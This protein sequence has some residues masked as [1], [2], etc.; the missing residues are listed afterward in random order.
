MYEDQTNDVI[1]NRMLG[2]VDSSIDKREGA[3]IY[4]ATAPAAFELELMYAELDYFLKNTFGDTAEREYL[5]ERALE[6]GLSPYEASAA[7][8]KITVTPTTVSVPVG[9][10][11]SYDDVNYTVTE[12][13]GGGEYLAVCETAGTAGN[14]PTGSLVSI[15]YIAG[16]KTATLTEIIVYGEEEED[17][18]SFRARYL[19]SFS[20]QAYGG[21]IKDYQN[22]VGAMD[23]V[24]GVKVYPVWNGGGTVKV[25]F[26]TSA[27]TVPSDELVAMVQEALD[28]VPYQQQGVGIAPIG[29]RV[30]VEAVKESA[31]NIGLNI[32]F[33]AGM[34]FETCRTSIE[35]VIQAYFDELNATWQDTEV[36][37]TSLFENTGLTVRVSQIE[38][39]LLQESYVSDISHT[40]LN[41]AEENLELSDDALATI[42]E[43]TD[44]SA[45]VGSD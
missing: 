9:S 41:G 10:R 30:T 25:V 29:H 23:G 26:T 17:T 3:I 20:T 35:A 18:E 40:T 39:R 36:V 13:L 8:V 37:T 31:I 14:K 16:L 22:R 11:F 15:D 44:I 19:A 1:L 7:T 6:R 2:R 5:I 43:I 4:D 32:A 34:D 28:P 42:G 33:I 27:Y 45:T 12:N 38:S 21:N 24:G